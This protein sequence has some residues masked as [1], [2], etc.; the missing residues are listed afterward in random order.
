M[1]EAPHK[2]PQLS[3]SMFYMWRALLAIAWADGNC[4]KEETAY[5][6][7]VFE[8][9]ARYFDLSQEQRN[10]LANDLEHPS[11]LEALVLFSH[12]N[13]PDVRGKLITFAHDLVMLDGELHP[14]E[15]DILRRL[16]LTEAPSLDREALKVEIQQI[17]VIGREKRTQ[18]KADLR[19]EIRNMSPLYAAVDRLLMAFGIDVID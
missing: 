12:I 14:N 11:E 9:L 17:I 8:N 2:K 7:K 16:R 5:F 1:Q 4:G 18:E 10:T 19:Q 13:D 3:T 6:A 15:E